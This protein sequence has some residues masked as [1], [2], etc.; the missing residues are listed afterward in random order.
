M[1]VESEF[2]FPHHLGNDLDGLAQPHVVGKAAVKAQLFHEFK[3]SDTAF[4]VF[5]QR[6]V[7]AGRVADGSDLPMV[8]QFRQHLGECVLRVNLEKFGF[9]GIAPKQFK[10]VQGFALLALRFP[11][12]QHFPHFVTVQGHPLTAKLDYWRF[13]IDQ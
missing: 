11:E 6:G 1:V 13:G 4:L 12:S 5:A 7:E 3:P 8:V 9:P 10:H 2:F